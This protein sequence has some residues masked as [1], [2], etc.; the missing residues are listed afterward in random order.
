MGLYVIQ[1][2][3]YLTTVLIN[4]GL[5]KKEMYLKYQIKS[6]DYKNFR[7]CGICNV[8]MNLDD[9]TS[10]CEDCNVCI[11]GHDHHCPWTSKCVGKGNLKPFYIFVSFTFVLMGFMFFGLATANIN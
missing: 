1:T 7:I 10:H 4:P 3:A 6:V 9:N 2:T 11:E 8:I 5:P